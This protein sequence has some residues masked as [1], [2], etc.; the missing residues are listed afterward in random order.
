[1][2]AMLMKKEVLSNEVLLF[3]PV[4]VIEGSFDEKN[5]YFMDKFNNRVVRKPLKRG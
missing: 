5:G 4:T 1:M 3:N 2:Y